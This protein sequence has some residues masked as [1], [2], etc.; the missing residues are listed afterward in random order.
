MKRIMVPMDNPYLSPG[1]AQTR[2]PAREAVTSQFVLRCVAFV[3]VLIP[4]TWALFGPV[5]ACH[6]VGYGLL[7]VMSSGGEDADPGDFVMFGERFWVL[8]D[9]IRR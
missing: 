8:P 1:N 9:S 2:R 3:A 6:D 4:V 5:W 7:I